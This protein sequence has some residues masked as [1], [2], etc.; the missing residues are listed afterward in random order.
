M[1]FMS[2]V[3]SD[4][5]HDNGRFTAFRERLTGETSIQTGQQSPKFDILSPVGG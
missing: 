1:G 3:R 5:Q 2:Y 4:D